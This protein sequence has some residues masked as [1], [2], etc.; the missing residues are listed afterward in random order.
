MTENIFVKPSALK[1]EK[2]LSAFS[3]LISMLVIFV[4]IA[5]IVNP[6]K[7]IAVSL[8]SLLVWAT[9]VLPAIFPFLLYSKFLTRLGIV[10]FFARL[11][12][13]ITKYLFNT[14]GISAYIYLISIIS[15]YP[16]GAKLTT[17]LY[18]DGRINRG[19]ALRTM[20]YCANS[21]PMFILGTVGI[22]MFASVKAGYVILISHFFGAILNGIVYR[23]Y[24]LNDQTFK[25]KKD[26]EQTCENFLYSTAI[27]S[28]NSML[29]V[30]TYIVV[31]FILI[32]FFSSFYLSNSIYS[33]IFNGLLEITHGCQDLSFLNI[34]MSIKTI[35]AT[36]IITFG[37][38]ST[39]MQSLAFLKKMKFSTPFFI[40][41]KFTH[42]LFSTIICVLLVL[43]F[44]L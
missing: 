22:G 23:K 9:V 40:L 33:A 27:S 3:F 2:K 14:D 36:F 24:R 35:L 41:L 42:A 25:Q 38:V 30:G 37:G 28:C 43:I 12:S 18:A 20:T 21:G 16:V 34:S 7:Y 4:I 1:K 32:E 17:D 44:K 29:I 6:E 11:I 10:D 15:G 8:N 39:T 13:P 26:S 31:F 5:M 19:S